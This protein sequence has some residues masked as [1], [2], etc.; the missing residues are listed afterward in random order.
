MNHRLWHF[1]VLIPHV[2]VHWTY[3]LVRDYR[4]IHRISYPTQAF[5]MIKAKVQRV[6]VLKS[7]N[8]QGKT[9]LYPWKSDVISV[10]FCVNLRRCCPG[11]SVLFGPRLPT[12]P[13]PA[14]QS[15]LELDRD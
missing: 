5:V 15:V 4:V 2:R 13:T 11:Y 10:E 12:E 14:V 6:N 7:L 9:Y 3:R 8:N 1:Y